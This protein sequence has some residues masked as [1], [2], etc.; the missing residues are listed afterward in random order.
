MTNSSAQQSSS[1]AGDATSATAAPVL[2]VRALNRATLA[3]QL[4]LHRSTRSVRTPSST[5]S[6][7]RHRTPGPRTTPSPP[8]WTVSRRSSSPRS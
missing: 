3:R 6:A 1:P 8:A 5:S 7:S 2:D 4:L